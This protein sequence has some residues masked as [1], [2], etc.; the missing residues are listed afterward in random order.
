VHECKSV[1]QSLM[2]ERVFM[3]VSMCVYK[4]VCVQVYVC[5]SM[6]VWKYV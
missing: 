2:Y 4:Y 6:C 1:N 5:V 3:C